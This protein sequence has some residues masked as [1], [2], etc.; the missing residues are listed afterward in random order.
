MDVAVFNA[1]GGCA[2]PSHRICTKRANPISDHE[3]TNVKAV[4]LAG[5]V[6]FGRCPLSSRLNRGF[7]PVFGRPAI[8]RTIEL[9]AAQGIAR[10]AVCCQSDSAAQAR[11]I[12]KPPEGTHVEFLNDPFPRGPA[13]CLRDAIDFVRDE[14]LLAVSGAIV[15]PPEAGQ[16]CRLHRQA[17]AL[18]SVFLNPEDKAVDHRLD[19]GIYVCSP[20]AVR[21][22]SEVGFMDIKEG[23][24]RHLV[25]TGNAPK[26]FT[27]D[28]DSGNFRT[29]QEYVL[30][31]QKHLLR[32]TQTAIAIE[33]Y[34]FDRRRMLWFEENA[35]MIPAVRFSG[36]VMISKG[37]VIEDGAIIEG[38]A[39][40]GRNVHVSG[41]S[42][43][44]E[45]I[46]WDDAVIRGASIVEGSLLAANTEISG[47]MLRCQLAARSSRKA[48][49]RAA[50]GKQRPQPAD[51]PAAAALVARQNL[52]SAVNASL[53]LLAVL[54]VTY[55]DTLKD[56]WSVWLRSDEYSSGLL[57]P[58][59][60]MYILWSRRGRFR[61]VCRPNPSMWGL[62]ALLGAQAF[63][64]FG[65]FYR[66]D[67]I[68]RL[69]FVLS[70]GALA[71][72]VGGQRL[73]RKFVPVFLFL[74][75]MLPFPRQVE[76]QITAP[77]QRWA[78][79]SAV[80]CLETFGFSVSHEGNVIHINNTLVAVAEACNGL[81][82][83]TAFLV[84]SG[85]VVLVIERRWWE[86]GL[87]LLSSIPIA[88]I[89]NTARL[90]VTAIF[91]TF[92]DTSR[93]E[94]VF[95]DFGGFAM[96]PAALM[97]IV[98]ELRI[99]SMLVVEPRRSGQGLMD[100]M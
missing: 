41:C 19:S 78:T 34:Y 63:R 54:V 31:V 64:L 42:T 7:W 79:S 56:L 74:F 80:F 99:L 12:I 4:I 18:L 48:A 17:G 33:G 13:G 85:M 21:M 92:L 97:I 43:I 50:L 10:F 49:K 65:L 75:L 100:P 45:S 38:P 88:L 60:A 84:V 46:V 9:L 86:K 71:V 89:C 22:I 81:R 8:Q 72:I 35:M 20:Q 37:S 1:C 77:L 15:S 53:L 14:L 55:W 98:L 90:T 59:V 96:M 87:V 2:R 39:I 3:L 28:V 66:Y 61:Q 26:A 82:M 30:A 5:T 23:L 25:R 76:M 73:F 6:D 57:V 47:Q 93:W 95:H 24:V 52:W 27:L 29:W 32:H 51:R 62:A 91:F 67:C 40:I 16:L 58:V 94:Q 44:R 68:E 36:P 70:V 83:L 11:S 69:S